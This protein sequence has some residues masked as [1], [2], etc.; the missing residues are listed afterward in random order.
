[1]RAHIKLADGTRLSP[2]PQS[3]L[4]ATFGANVVIGDAVTA[5]GANAYNREAGPLHGVAMSK[6]ADSKGTRAFG[7]KL[8]V[9]AA[10]TLTPGSDK[11][12][13]VTT[14]GEVSGGA[15]A[16]GNAWHVIAEETVDSQI[17]AL[18]EKL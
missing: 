10:A 13:T 16:A 3:Q 2:K 15:V 5:T 12:L 6:E 4:T 9:K 1:M 7:G 14:D 11:A 17:Y 18:V 8:I